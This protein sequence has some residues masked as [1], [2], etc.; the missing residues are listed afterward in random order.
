MIKRR[1]LIT[2][3]C[4]IGAVALQILLGYVISRSFWVVAAVFSVIFSVL[5]YRWLR[6]PHCGDQGS[7]AGMSRAMSRP[8]HCRSC[9]KRL[10][11]GEKND[12]HDAK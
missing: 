5:A 1:K 12:A 11:I 4:L 8:T 3:W 2:L 7:L 10:I 9:G 6:C